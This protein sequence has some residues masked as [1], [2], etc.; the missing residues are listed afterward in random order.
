[1]SKEVYKLT[2]EPITCVHIGNGKELT[3]LDYLLKKSKQGNDLYLAY[4]TD[5][6]FRRIAKDKSKS[7][8]F[9]QLS[10]TQDMKELSQFFNDEFNVSEDL[11]YA[12]D[13]TKEF[14]N[15]YA[16]NKNIDPLQNGRFVLQ[17]YRPEGKKAPVV[18]GSSIKGSIRTAVLNDL[19][20]V[21]SDNDYDKLQD[22]FSKCNSGFQKKN[23][24]STVQN[25]LFNNEKERDKAKHDPFRAIEIADCNFEAKNTQLVG[26]IKNV[27]KNNQN[28]IS[29]CNSS[30]VQAEVIRGKL[31]QSENKIIGTAEMRLNKDLAMPSLQQKGVSKEISKEDIIKAC[32]YFYWREFEN[33]YE[34]FYEEA[35]DDNAKLITQLYKELKQIKESDCN[36]FI[37]RV[38]RWSQVEFVTFEENFRAPQNKK[39]GTTR[40]VFDYDGFYLPL[41]WCK[42][43]ITSEE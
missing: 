2:V 28:E 35:A 8:L 42:C 23:F 38:G 13:T 17:M 6:I 4:D 18:P 43:T 14:A 24:E 9:E 26:I 40:W 5:S 30:L 37:L 11:K 10:S 25:K 22:D 39:Y 7:A 32:N 3:P 20:S 21:L 34:T 12:C 33:E 29:V 27:A 16:K 15:N 41:G 19:M 36:S 1:M 31:C